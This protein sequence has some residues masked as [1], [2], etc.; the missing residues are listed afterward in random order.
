MDNATLDRPK[1]GRQ[2]GFNRMPVAQAKLES[3]QI[4]DLHVAASG[5][6]KFFWNFQAKISVHNTVAKS[7][8]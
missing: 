8:K 7:I 2:A 4:K 1:R 5:M 3:N 6:H